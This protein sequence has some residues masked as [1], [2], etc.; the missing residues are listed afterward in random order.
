MCILFLLNISSFSKLPHISWLSPTKSV[1]LY[2]NFKGF[3]GGSD[4]CNAGDRSSS[5]G[6]VRSPGEG[7]G[8]PLH[9][10]CLENPMDRGA[11]R[12]TVNG[13][14]KSLSWL[15]GSFHLAK[16]SLLQRKLISLQFKFC[17]IAFFFFF[18]L[19]ESKC[20]YCLSLAYNAFKSIFIFI[21]FA[22]W[23]NAS[24]SCNTLISMTTCDLSVLQSN[25]QGQSYYE[26]VSSSFHNLNDWPI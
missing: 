6:L 20:C 19:V 10:S 5:P 17:R 16:I 8:Y 23:F 12:A 21:F 25:P 11:W 26:H 18:F 2:P 9:Y 1:C 13:V 4:G 24:I 15:N 22:I 3:P 14:T 7:N